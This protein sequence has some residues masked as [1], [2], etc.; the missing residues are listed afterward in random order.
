MKHSK[1]EKEDEDKT[2]LVWDE[3][4]AQADCDGRFTREHEH[5]Q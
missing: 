1:Q 3:V 2:K 4:V 5:R